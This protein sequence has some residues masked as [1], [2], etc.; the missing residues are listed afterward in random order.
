MLKIAFLVQFFF[1]DNFFVVT[2]FI[3]VFICSFIALQGLFTPL[4]ILLSNEYL[5][6][7]L[8][9]TVASVVDW[10][11]RSAVQQM[12]VGIPPATSYDGGI[13]S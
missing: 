7:L 2:Y 10:S 12:R 9:V 1:K 3:F 8:Y 13:A 6:G 11:V 4:Y 5:T